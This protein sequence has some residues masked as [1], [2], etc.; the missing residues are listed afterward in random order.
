[1]RQIC[2]MVMPFGTK[3]TGLNP[4]EGTQQI[5][6]RGIKHTKSLP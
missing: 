5:R 2:F 3:S 4:G 6:D 1:M